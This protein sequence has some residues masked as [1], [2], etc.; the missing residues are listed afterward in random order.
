MAV[1]KAANSAKQIEG[2]E[3]WCGNSW[4]HALLKGVCE[5][6]LQSVRSLCARTLSVHTQLQCFFG[7]VN[8]NQLRDNGVLK[9]VFFGEDVST[10]ALV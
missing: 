9:L 1:K 2:S 8:S 6:L 3:K 5:R 7:L 10:L 4:Y